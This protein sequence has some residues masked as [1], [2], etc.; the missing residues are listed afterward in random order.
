MREPI[1]N[2]LQTVR[3]WAS[4]GAGGGLHWMSAKVIA[5]LVL[6]F[7]CGVA[8]GVGIAAIGRDSQE[9]ERLAAIDWVSAINP[10]ENPVYAVPVRVRRHSGSPEINGAIKAA[11]EDPAALSRVIPDTNATLGLDPAVAV[12]D[13]E[14]SDL[15]AVPKQNGS[16]PVQVGWAGAQSVAPPLDNA[17]VMSSSTPRDDGDR[18]AQAATAEPIDSTGIA[19]SASN[20][21]LS[22]PQ[23]HSHAAPNAVVVDQAPVQPD[24]VSTAPVS[25]EAAVEAAPSEPEIASEPSPETDQAPAAAGDPNSDREPGDMVIAALPPQTEP[26]WIR[27]AAETNVPTGAPVIAIII[28]DMGIDQK[29]SRLAIALPSPAWFRTSWTPA[30]PFTVCAT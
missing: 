3:A 29:R 17:A 30:S 23:S 16:D 27:N 5:G 19:A 4:R 24:A 6:A 22:P 26:L 9:T 15:L 7:G 8:L 11:A 2:L 25:S 12:A 28:D 13:P 14:T 10:A 21:V 1:A 18:V 20:D